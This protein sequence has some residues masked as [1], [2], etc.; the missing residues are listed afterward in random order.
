M[1]R[2][3][4][5]PWVLLVALLAAGTL[6]VPSGPADARMTDYC[7]VPPYV[8]QNIP[9]N[10]LILLDTS[11]SMLNNAYYDGYETK[12]DTS[13]DRSCT[14]SAVCMK[15]NWTDR[16]AAHRYYGYFDPNKWYTY[17]SGVFTATANRTWVVGETR[18]ANT[19]G[20]DFLNWL[21]MRDRKSVV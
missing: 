10:V 18:P 7:Q 12:T 15:Y 4:S 2:R 9:P 19:W 8:I 3:H 1:N 16:P 5:F 20:G 14:L 17:A 11:G 13:D 21:T 6:A